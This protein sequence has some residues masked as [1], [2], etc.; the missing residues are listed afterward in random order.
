MMY[1]TQGE[2]ATRL[3][4]RY[5]IEAT[6]AIGDVML[7]SEALRDSGPFVADVDLDEED[8]PL[9]YALLDWVALYAHTIKEDEPGAVLTD[10]MAPFSRTYA[11]PEMTRNGKRLARL[12]APYLRHTGRVA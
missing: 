12:I 8:S 10:N 11:R 5:G 2:A 4:E 6:L 7:A 9:P 3:R 1:M